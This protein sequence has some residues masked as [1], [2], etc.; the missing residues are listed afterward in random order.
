MKLMLLLREIHA[1]LGPLL[2]TADTIEISSSHR[3]AA[4]NLI[5]AIIER[6]QISDTAYAVDAILDD[7]VWD[8]LFNIFLERSDD[9]KSKSVRQV[10]LVLTNVLSRSTS[11]RSQELQHRAATIFIDIICRRKD[12]LKVKPALQGLSNLLQKEI[13]PLDKLFDYYRE[14]A[15]HQP[16]RLDN[17]STAQVL[18]AEILAWIVHH[19]TSLSAGHLLKNYLTQLRNWPSLKHSKDRNHAPI[20]LHPV[21]ECLHSWPDRMQE[22]K[23]HVF[24]YCFLPNLEEFLQFLSFLHF[25]KHVESRRGLPCQLKSSTVTASLLEENEEF[26]IL[27][28]SVEKAKELAIVKDIGKRNATPHE[29]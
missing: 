8:R 25:E 22:F 29:S 14:I 2:D 18:L 6:C 7:T 21:L 17:F 20:W 4:C 3:A 5:C 15:G 12:R 1:V 24:P 13:V 26:R 27:L 16:D 10:L 11:P 28:A 19:D 9:A 23:T